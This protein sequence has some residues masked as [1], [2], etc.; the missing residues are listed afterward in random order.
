MSVLLLATIAVAWL[1][2]SGVFL[3]AC[4]TAARADRLAGRTAPS[5]CVLPDQLRLI[6]RNILRG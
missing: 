3:A 1:A 6:E 5:R 4:V 2:V